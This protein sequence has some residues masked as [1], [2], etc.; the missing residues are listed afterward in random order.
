MRRLIIIAAIA[1]AA[2][3]GVDSPIEPTAAAQREPTPAERGC[4]RVELPIEL[5][6]VE[7]NGVT[8]VVKLGYWQCPDTT[9]VD[10]TASGQ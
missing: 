7:I 3:T 4:V 6:R 9:A 10:T 5:G 2:C 1:A 8:Y